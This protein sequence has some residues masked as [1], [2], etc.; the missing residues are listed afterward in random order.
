[1]PV[2]VKIGD[3]VSHSTLQLDVHLS[4]WPFPEE[5]RAQNFLKKS[6][7]ETTLRKSQPLKSALQSPRADEGIRY[8][9]DDQQD[10]LREN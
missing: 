4:L 2:R 8:V 3:W 10:L 6:G 7:K 1:M 5:K 9:S